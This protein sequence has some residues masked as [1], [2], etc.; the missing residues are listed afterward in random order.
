MTRFKPKHPQGEY[1]GAAAMKPQYVLI[2]GNG[3][4]RTSHVTVPKIM[5]AV[6][7][8]ASNKY[9]TLEK[10]RP[11]RLV[12]EAEYFAMSFYR[13]S[14]IAVYFRVRKKC[15]GWLKAVSPAKR[16]PT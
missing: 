14:R 8:I 7:K 11:V 3:E 2:T 5:E 12:R 13:D 10:C 15:S 4:E 16:L 9:V 1:L 6:Y